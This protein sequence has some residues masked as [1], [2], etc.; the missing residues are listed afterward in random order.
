MDRYDRPGYKTKI[1]DY[2]RSNTIQLLPGLLHLY[3][4]KTF[5][6]DQSIKTAFLLYADYNLQV[7]HYMTYNTVQ[8]T[9]INYP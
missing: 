1:I 8:N 2:D 5:Q 4:S 6:A 7:V 9:K 3:S